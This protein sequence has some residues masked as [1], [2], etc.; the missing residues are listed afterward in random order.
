MSTSR[1]LPKCPK[2]KVAM[3]TRDFSGTPVEVCPSCAGFYLDEHELAAIRALPG[4]RGAFTDVAPPAAA[5]PEAAFHE[6]PKCGHPMVRHPYADTAVVV[7]SCNV[8]GGL[9]LDPGEFGALLAHA[10][11]QAEA[12]DVDPALRAALEAAKRDAAARE[13]AA[14]TA[15]SGGVSGAVFGLLRRLL[16]KAGV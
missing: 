5:G 7:D 13:T 8:C 4:A 15:A 12:G 2:C 14:L 11:R 6:C 9:W 16:H 3:E 1:P 10:E